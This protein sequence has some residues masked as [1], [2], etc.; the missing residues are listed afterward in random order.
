M[1]LHKFMKMLSFGACEDFAH[2]MHAV[3]KQGGKSSY[4]MVGTTLKAGHHSSKFDFDEDSLLA[5]IDV[6]VRSAYT[7]NKNENK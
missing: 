6:F 2:F 4:L 5:G 7:I 3:Q 1:K